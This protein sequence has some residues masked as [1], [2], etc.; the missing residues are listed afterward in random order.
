MI[1][2]T[3]Y[4]HYTLIKDETCLVFKPAIST[5]SFRPFQRLF[6]RRS[7]F[8]QNKKDFCPIDVLSSSRRSLS[9]K[10]AEADLNMDDTYD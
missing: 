6:P 10:C 5:D 7:E 2:K 9:N 8:D 4:N 3:S 1:T